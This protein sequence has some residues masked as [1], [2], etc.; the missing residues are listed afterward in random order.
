MGGLHRS[1]TTLLAALVGTNPTV[2]G[3][4][5]TGAPMDEGQY[6]QT[7]CPYDEQHGGPGRFAY[8]PG[9][10]MTEHHELAG[11]ATARLLRE[12]WGRYLDPGRPVV[13][14][15]S[16]P[17]LL[18]FRFFQRLFPGSRFV[19][20]M[21]HPVA[22]AMSTR[23]WTPALTVRQLVEHW[24]HAHELARADAAHVDAMLTVR[25]E[26]LMDDPDRTLGAS[27][28]SPAFHP[29]STSAAWTG[30]RTPATCRP[31]GRA[32]GRR[33]P[34]RP[35]RPGRT[36]RLPAARARLNRLRLR[37]R[38][39]V[40]AAHRARHRRAAALRRLG[41][42]G[43][44]RLR[45]GRS[46]AGRLSRG[47]AGCRPGQPRRPGPPTGRRRQRSGRRDRTAAALLAGR[48]LR[49]R[50]RC[51]AGRRGR[52]GRPAGL[53]PILLRPDRRGADR[54]PRQVL[55]FATGAAAGHPAID[56]VRA[57]LTP[58]TEIV[59]G[60]C[61]GGA[62]AALALA[63]AGAAAPA[64]ITLGAP[65]PPAV[66]PPA[67][68]PAFW[69]DVADVQDTLLLAAG[70]GPAGVTGRVS[71][72]CD[73]G[74][75]ALATIWP[76]RSSARCSAACWRR[77]TAVDLRSM[78][79]TRHGPGRG[80]PP[81]VSMIRVTPSERSAVMT[82]TIVEHHPHRES[83]S[84]RIALVMIN[85][86]LR[87]GLSVALRG[88]ALTTSV[89]SYRSMPELLTEAVDKR[90]EVLVVNAADGVAG[91]AAAGLIA[92]RAAR[93]SC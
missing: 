48:H 17:N 4:R 76:R 50:G 14:E 38:T 81:S 30:T 72:D 54:H 19:L 73:L 47:G 55:A 29:P 59:I 22:V 85:D 68:G 57:A 18:R 25:Y 71:L 52:V 43:V 44:D 89:R 3:F 35:R 53:V 84:L 41:P 31:G 74:C 82:A 65:H 79:G 70:T 60:H 5:Q 86:I 87:D 80:V 16:P 78:S 28:P 56:A 24:L 8:A 93:S 6:L 83:A 90:P 39:D 42:P 27:R 46:G 20:V 15:K 58:D 13:L 10:H 12:Q 61:L 49:H 63:D 21:R 7:V 66:G 92:P 9:A 34:R 91:I 23:K 77:V 32:R 64:L 88:L 11:P 67:S 40:P 51:G 37:G 2:A 26:D 45:R 1:G 36:V 33:R 62:A 75:A 69:V